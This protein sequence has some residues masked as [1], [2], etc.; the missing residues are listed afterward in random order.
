MKN[1]FQINQILQPEFTVVLSQRAGEEVDRGRPVF[2][3]E[4]W[5][6]GLSIWRRL[7]R[8]A[9]VSWRNV[10]GVRPVIRRNSR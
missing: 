3:Q 6:D 9:T 1:Q 5:G 10:S 7:S 8:L 2:V 4:I